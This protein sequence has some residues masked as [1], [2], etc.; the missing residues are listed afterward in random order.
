MNYRVAELLSPEDL[1][2]S[3]TEV[4]DIDVQQP[5][6]R[7]ELH[8]KVT[9]SKSAMDAGA[10]A[11]IT[12]VELV[13][14]SNRLVIATGYELAALAYYNRPGVVLNHGQ[15][16]T[17]N[18]QHQV[19]PIDFGRW[20]WDEQLAFDPLKFTNPQLRITW[21]EALSDTGVT[22]NELEVLAHIFDEK[23]IS[24]E[25]FLSP[26]E[27]FDYTLGANNSFEVIDIPDDRPIRQM[28]VRA[29]Q[30]GFE[31]WYSIDEARF[32]EGT[33]NKI[34]F[35]YT[36]LENY[37]RRMK[38]VWPLIVYP[39]QISA[40]AATTVIYVP[41]TQYYAQMVGVQTSGEGNPFVAA[42]G[43][44]GGKLNMDAGSSID[45][46]A[47]IAGHLPWHCYQF[48]M[49]M[50]M[51]IDDWYNPARKKPRLR[52]RASTGATSST[53]QLL[54]EELYRY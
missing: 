40:K 29:Y 4:I 24:P 6:S 33:L 27:H 20:L 50:P 32:D 16:T 36:N 1:G 26:I 47:L 3:G 30:D 5:I 18:S 14:G 2:A 45:V 22:A 21:N 15:H 44:R 52:L 31:P 9:K 49:G 28:L 51:K 7:I 12:K 13:D 23:E 25:G 41:T 8:W 42:A 54:L 34:A 35:E 46:D 19:I 48:P 53:G 43:G 10:P 38:S 37:Y 17:G 11:D 39:C